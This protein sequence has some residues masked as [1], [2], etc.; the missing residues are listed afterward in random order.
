[1]RFRQHKDASIDHPVDIAREIYFKNEKFRTALYLRNTDIIMYHHHRVQW[2]TGK[3][4]QIIYVYAFD[5]R[6][7]GVKINLENP[8]LG[9]T[10][11][12]SMYEFSGSF[13]LWKSRRDRESEKEKKRKRTQAGAHACWPT[14]KSAP[15]H[16]S[17]SVSIPYMHWQQSTL[18]R[19]SNV[20]FRIGLNSPRSSKNLRY[21]SQ[22]FTPA[23]TSC[24]LH[25]ASGM[26]D[27]PIS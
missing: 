24:T 17:Q 19:Q 9:K 12:L 5:Q 22:A 27:R 1:M 21:G 7:F 26:H 2:R 10:P 20:Q 6:L 16:V 14:P 4:S 15:V 8:E 23:D 25:V 3:L 13:A 11:A 18:C